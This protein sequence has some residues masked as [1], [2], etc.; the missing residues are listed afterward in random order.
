MARN[1]S[2][3]RSSWFESSPTEDEKP[4]EAT[5]DLDYDLPERVIAQNPPLTNV[6]APDV[7]DRL[8]VVQLSRT[9]PIA[10][11]GVHGGAGAT[12]IAALDAELFLDCGA[13]WPDSPNQRQPCLLVSRS[14][15]HGL[16]ALQTALQQWAAA[17]TPSVE[18]LGVVV[19][20]DAPG[21]LPKPLDSL[22]RVVGGGAPRLWR[23]PWDPAMRLNT[24][25]EP[26]RMRKSAR[27]LRNLRTLVST[28]KENP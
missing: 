2:D 8:P 26:V 9:R 24:E 23:L 28:E 18:L 6:T 16:Y 12:S 22:L 10:V 21:K 17:E 19:I 4:A 5:V 14:S 3:M 11:V 1:R 27:L 7:T 15:A 25:S 20:A 13:A